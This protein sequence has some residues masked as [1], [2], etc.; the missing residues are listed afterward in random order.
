MA[1]ITNIEEGIYGFDDFAQGETPYM[2][3]INFYSENEFIQQQ[4]INRMDELARKVGYKTFKTTFK[5]Y[6]ATEAKKAQDAADKKQREESNR[7]AFTNQPAEI[8]CG[9]WIADDEGVRGVHPITR[10]LV[11]ACPH[12][13]MPYRRLEN[14]D[15]GTTKMDIRFRNARGIWEQII[16]DRS[17]IA[18]SS[19]I[20]S[21][22]DRGISV[23]SETAKDL[24]RY[25]LDCESKSTAEQI[26]N[27]PSVGR[28]GYIGD[29]GF[30]P[31]C[32]DLVFDGD[33]AYKKL[34]DSVHEAGDPEVWKENMIEV[35][36]NIG[37]RLV[38]DASFASVVLA[39][40]SILPFFV[41]LW[42]VESGTGKTVALMCAVSV[43][44][45]PSEGQYIQ[46]WNSTAVGR[47][48]YAAFLNNL[49]IVFDELQLDRAKNSENSS[50]K[51][52][53]LAQG[54]GRTRGTKTGLDSTSSWSSCIISSG[55]TPITSQNQGAGALNRA[56]E[57]ECSTSEKIIE[58]GHGIAEIVKNN[59][60]YSGREW[61]KVLEDP[62]VLEGIRSMRDSFMETAIACGITGKQAMAG[63]IL[64]AVDFA[65]IQ[66]IFDGQEDLL[67]D[68]DLI[69]FLK[70]N[71]DVDINR[72]A[73]QFLLG[74]I[75]Q[76]RAKFDEASIEIYGKI[77]KDDVTGRDT[78]IVNKKVFDKALRDEG[79]SPN[80]LVK[81][82]AKNGMIVQKN[83]CNTY[84]QYVGGT[85]NCVE[86]LLPTPFEE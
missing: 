60:G 9:S 40:L 54:S 27:V 14:V 1:D 20:V 13:I 34:F 7:T 43:W 70:T 37:A 74:W 24:V 84:N 73:H 75:A 78:I 77:G 79:F 58:D 45:D 32:N 17:I 71:A 68:D 46:T 22:A 61:I 19:R 29:Y 2:E 41:H 35:R 12:P 21:L 59:F 28:L 10:Q 49:P 72:R 55:E 80:A 85:C 23:T 15:T 51:L 69:Q 65:V 25:F 47:E 44:A 67:N 56:I 33:L 5:K 62:S 64:Y 11:V 36:K 38:I 81:W 6:Q 57:I 30:S 66:Y 42:G 53:L 3:I 86:I 52:Y 4:A 83:G 82:M 50:T 31:Y 76:N 48:R 39:K 16:I 18:S 26:V 8:S 63:S